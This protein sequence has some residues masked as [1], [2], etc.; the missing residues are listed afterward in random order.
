VN[1]MLIRIY[2]PWRGKCDWRRLRNKELR[3]LYALPNIIGLI[4]LRRMSWSGH[5]ARMGEIRN[6]YKSLVGI[7]ERR[8]LGGPT[9]R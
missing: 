9:N 8:S 3:N 1:L 7:P 6:L 2:G 4:K 5:V